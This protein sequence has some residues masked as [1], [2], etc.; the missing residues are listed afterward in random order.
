MFGVIGALAAL[1]EARAN[2]HGQEVDVAIY[3][4]VAALTE[5][6]MADFDLGGVLRERSGSVL[7]GVA[8]SNVY[9]T[10]DGSEVLIAGNADTVFGRLCEAMGRPEL[11][12]DARFA[13][14][15]ARGTNMEELDSII[16]SWTT[17]LTRDELQATLEKHAIPSGRIYTARDMLEDP[18]YLARDMVLRMRSPQGWD[19]PMTGVVPRFGRTR[20]SV[21][22]AGPPLGSDTVAV[23]RDVAGC[24]EAEIAELRDASLLRDADADSGQ[25]DES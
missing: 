14:H 7:P 25:E 5:S 10:G 11:A 19:V 23:L 20:G 21:R 3:E 15:A 22:R 1:T 2:G 24:S 13:A 6:S 4:A 17:S 8:P 18:H 12:T 9:A 16:A